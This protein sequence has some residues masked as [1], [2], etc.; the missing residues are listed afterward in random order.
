MAVLAVARMHVEIEDAERRA[1]VG[2][3]HGKLAHVDVPGTIGG[4]GRRH[5]VKLETK[6]VL[7]EREHLVD[8]LG[9]RK[10]LLDRLVVDGESAN[11]AA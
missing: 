5:F 3:A 1:G 7:I 4:V 10:I 9:E 2:V 11:E 6:E 8:D